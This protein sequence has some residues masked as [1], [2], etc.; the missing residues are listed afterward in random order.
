LPVL[1]TPSAYTDS[2]DFSD[3]NW[4]IPTLEAKNLPD[5]LR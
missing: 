2:D 3:A 1:V 5:E 4:V